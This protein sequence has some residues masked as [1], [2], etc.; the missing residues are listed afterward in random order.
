MALDNAIRALPRRLIKTRRGFGVGEVP[1][2]P[3][4]LIRQL[5]ISNLG[6]MH[7]GDDIFV[8]VYLR[9]RPDTAQLD[10]GRDFLTDSL[11]RTGEVDDD[12][13]I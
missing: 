4:E 7:R 5:G 13:E 11:K 2:H 3:S 6:S 12:E 9:T 1:D 10:F 8:S